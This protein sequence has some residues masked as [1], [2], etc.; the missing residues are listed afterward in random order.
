[1]SLECKSKVW[2]GALIFVNFSQG[3]MRTPTSSMRNE[4]LK[5]W[6]KGLEIYSNTNRE[7]S[8]LDR[9]KAIKLSADIAMASTTT[10]S[11]YWSRAI[12]AKASKHII[13]GS[14]NPSS[15]YNIHQQKMMMIKKTSNYMGKRIRSKKIL[16]KS[17]T[18]SRRVKRVIS[19]NGANSIAKKLV[20]KR[21]QVLK[22]LVP[23]GEFM[24]DEVCLI[25]ETLDY[26]VSL[27]LQVDVM[28]RLANAT[29]VELEPKK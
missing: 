17:C 24:E 1:M 9:K 22:S 20:K 14:K 21:T 26:I 8:I 5:R 4:F 3:I 23:G 11:T 25:R 12:M 27:R 29:T 19:Q 15:S 16:R 2:K 28:R 18:S 6:L 13:L 10:C 7:M